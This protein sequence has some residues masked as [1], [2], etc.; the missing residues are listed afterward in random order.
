MRQKEY[1]IV[2][3]IFMQPFNAARSGANAPMAGANSLLQGKAS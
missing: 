1:W 3:A 2:M